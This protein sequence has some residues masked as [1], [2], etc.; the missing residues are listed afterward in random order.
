[1]TEP[2]PFIEA[3][4]ASSSPPRRARSTGGGPSAPA[5]PWRPW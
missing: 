1:M 2:V 3:L 5:A 4:R